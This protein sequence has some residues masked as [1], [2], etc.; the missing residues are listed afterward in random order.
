MKHLL[1][2]F[3]FSLLFF[4]HCSIASAVTN[5]ISI[6]PNSVEMFGDSIVIAGVSAENKEVIQVYNHELKEVW[7]C[8]VKDRANFIGGNI[9]GFRILSNSVVIV[10]VNLNVYYNIGV[11][12]NAAQFSVMV[13]VL[14]Y[15]LSGGKEAILDELL[16]GGNEKD[17]TR[18]SDLDKKYGISA[19]PLMLRFE[20]NP[21]QYFNRSNVASM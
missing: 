2:T 11:N 3:L 16:T 9:H 8:V 13:R 18:A 14:E 21:G 5:V 10:L 20:Q 6:K 15:P 12:N 1:S 4:W 19:L 7:S 17:K